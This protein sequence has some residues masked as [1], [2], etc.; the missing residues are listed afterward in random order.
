MEVFDTLVQFATMCVFV[1]VIDV[2]WR[3]VFG[4]K[5]KDKIVNG[6]R[7]IE[8]VNSEKA[9]RKARKKSF[10]PLVQEIE[11]PKA[12]YS[13]FAIAIADDSPIRVLVVHYEDYSGKI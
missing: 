5:S 8:T 1:I 12:I 7:V 10:L 6:V 9:V 2:I 3:M 13:K 4:Q 11:Q